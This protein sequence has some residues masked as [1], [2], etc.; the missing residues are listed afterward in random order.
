MVFNE[1]PDIKDL[2]AL[3]EIKDQDEAPKTP[4]PDKVAEAY[5]DG[6]TGQGRLFANIKDPKAD[7]L[8]LQGLVYP[9]AGVIQKTAP[10]GALALA[11]GELDEKKKPNIIIADDGI[12][13][14]SEIEISELFLKLRDGLTIQTILSLSNWAYNHKSN[15]FYHIPLTDVLRDYFGKDP[16]YKLKRAVSDRIMTLSRCKFYLNPETHSIKNEA[17]K[18]VPFGGYFDIISLGGEFTRKKGGIIKKLYG[19]LAPGIDF[20]RFRGEPFSGLAKL[21]PSKEDERIVLGFLLQTTMAQHHQGAITIS[22]G[23][24]ITKAGLEKSNKLNPSGASKKLLKSL[25]RLK[26]IGTIADY[27]PKAITTDD[28]QEITITSPF[29]TTRGLKKTNTKAIS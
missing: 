19:W 14:V 1:I 9:Y 4:D 28:R 25:E 6:A 20:W 11:S 15:Q 29:T 24:L 16:G 3:P 23:E 17:G 10:R 5:F 12:K 7:N 21:D 8:V 13:Q 2:E 18:T 22:R 27:T 26:E